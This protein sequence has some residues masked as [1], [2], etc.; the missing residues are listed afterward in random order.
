MIQ[1]TGKCM[2]GNI[3]TVT[4]CTLIS[5]IW[6]FFVL[7]F[8]R[9]NIMVNV[10]HVIGMCAVTVVASCCCYRLTDF[11][12]SKFKNDYLM[13]LI[14]LILFTVVYIVFVVKTPY[15]PNHDSYDLEYILKVMKSGA[16]MGDY[17]K[18]YMPYIDSNK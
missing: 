6:S 14:A 10:Y 9:E 4:I 12:V 15:S 8:L 5:L 17:L 16:V 13:Y 1:K 2:I 3:I 7:N 11:F 18:A